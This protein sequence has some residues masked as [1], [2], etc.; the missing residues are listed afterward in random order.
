MSDDKVSELKITVNIDLEPLQAVLREMS[1]M[2]KEWQKSIECG[3]I[4]WEDYN[5]GMEGFE[6]RIKG[7]IDSLINNRVT[8]N[9]GK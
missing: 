5:R 3:S 7:E 1:F 4:S 6:K 8:I 2:R 9:L